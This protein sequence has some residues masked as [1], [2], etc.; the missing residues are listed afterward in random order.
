[1]TTQRPVLTTVG[2][3]EDGVWNRATTLVPPP[4]GS[5]VGWAVRF[6]WAA[7][8]APAVI[9]RGTSG[10]SE[11]YRD[12]LAAT[13]TRLLA[14]KTRVVV[15]DATIEPTSRH[16]VAGRSRVSVV[17]RSLV[18]HLARALV[19]S[20]DSPRVVWCVL[21]RAEVDRFPR[22]WGTTRGTVR[23]TPFTHTLV[24]SGED[25]VR[26]TG[27]H[28]F[29]GGNSLR[30]HA[31]L[32]EAVAG[33]G[34]RVVVASSWRPV[35]PQA[36]VEVRT[37]THEEFVELMATSRGV[38]L[39][40]EPAARSTGQQTYL[41]AMAVGRPTIVT[42]ADGVRDHIEDGVTG[43]VAPRTVEGVR[44]AVSDLLD[45]ARADV[46]ASMGSRARDAARTGFSPEA[47]RAR[48]LAIAREPAA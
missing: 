28:L 1:M 38:V 44:A 29:S 24:R 3:S 20:V 4:S 7:R 45:A 8:R 13:A 16:L 41:N 17:A 27:D 9:V 2:A 19:R 14:P 11:R 48:L 10:G 21:S 33:L 15:S 39:C 42:E 23:F 6:G 30:D 12:L 25:R 46:Y 31:L 18:P 34:V 32:Q 40:L 43:V 37:A 22:T 36:D 26:P 35:V 47:Y 5:A